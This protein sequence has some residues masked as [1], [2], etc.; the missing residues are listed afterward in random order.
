VEIANTE[1]KIYPAGEKGRPRGCAGHLNDVALRMRL[2][3]GLE[4]MRPSEC[5]VPG[6]AVRLAGTRLSALERGEDG[7][8]TIRC[9]RARV[10]VR[11]CERT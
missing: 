1:Q 4:M 9:S 2:R 10:D 6:R 7:P 3:E 11:N 8:P 5:M